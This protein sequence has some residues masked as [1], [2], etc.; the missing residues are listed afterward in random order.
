MNLSPQ[1]VRLVLL[2][3]QGLHQPPTRPATRT[4][5]LSIIRQMSALQLDTIHV[6]AR[7][8]ILVV[9]SRLGRYD[10][11]WLDELLAERALFEYWSH[12]ACLLPIEDYPLYRRSMLDGTRRLSSAH[13]WLDSNREVTERVLAHIH[14]HGATRSA[15]F[16]RTDGQQ[17]G[18]WN[19][20]AEK[21]A[22]ENLHTTGSLMIASRQAFQRLYDLRERI[23]PAWDDAQAPDPDTVRRALVCKAVRALGV[24]TARW[25][26]DYFRMPRAGMAELLDD[27]VATGELLRVTVDEWDEPAYIHP[28]NLELAQAAAAGTL[29][30]TH[31][32][33]LSPFDPLVWDRTRARELFGFDYRLECY[34]PAPRRRYGYFSL[35]ILYQGELVGRLDPK[36]HR[37]AG[38]FEVK[39]LHLEPAVPITDHLTSAIA[40]A[41]QACATWHGTP[42][43]VVR[44]SDPPAVAE[45]I[46]A[47]TRL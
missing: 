39:A 41:L 11:C 36:A 22:L 38:F 4:D 27:L 23:L 24:T 19:W 10:P 6:V 17:S 43:V 28:D 25:V 14:T 47:Q 16:T 46:E 34:T 26:P 12:E 35:P 15:D 37:K 30:A 7:S 32:T 31:T 3:A 9:W 13:Q 5:V 20:K 8:H 33:L 29:Q 40:A 18:W 45:Q 2:A 21:R 42:E 44:W 1:A